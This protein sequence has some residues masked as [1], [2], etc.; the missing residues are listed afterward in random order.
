ML[1]CDKKSD[2]EMSSL[3]ITD[4]IINIQL[5]NREDS[6]ARREIVKG[7]TRALRKLEKDHI[8]KC[9]SPS[10]KNRPLYW[11]YIDN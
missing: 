11:K 6:K 9:T 2:K 8:V 5:I 4:Y 7:V 1:R 10:P 3:E